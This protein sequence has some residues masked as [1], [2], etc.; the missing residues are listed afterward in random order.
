MRAQSG[1]GSRRIWLDG[2]S[3]VEKPLVVNLLEE[4]PE[5]LDVA[6]VIC[7]VWIVHVHPVSYTLGHVHPLGGVFHHLLAACVVVL[8]H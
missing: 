4:E 6:V 5:S 1:A 2:L 3:L 7:D 8:L